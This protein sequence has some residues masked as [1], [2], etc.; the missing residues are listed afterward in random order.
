MTN[1]KSKIK[2]LILRHCVLPSILLLA[3]WLQ[4]SLISGAR[5]HPDE[6][7]YATWARV[8]ATG[9]DVWLAQR[10]VDKPPL[11]IYAI[12]IPFGTV[13]ASEEL[14]RLPNVLA[15]LCA[16]ALLYGIAHSLYREHG[17]AWLAAGVFALSPYTLLFAPTA[18]TDPFMLGWV[19]LAWWL[20][21]K[22]R[23]FYAGIAYGLALA[24][25]QDAILLLPLL[26]IGNWLLAMSYRKFTIKYL[27][28]HSQYLASFLLGWLLPL[29]C[30]MGWS[31]L[32]PQLNYLQAS[33]DHYGGVSFVTFDSYPARLYA[34]V[35][36][37]R[38]LSSEWLL[39]L[40]I[41]AS[42]FLMARQRHHA[43]IGVWLFACYWFVSH[44][45][46]SLQVWDR[47]L[48]PLAPIAA[49]AIARSVTFAWRHRLHRF[50]K[51]GEV[52]FIVS[53]AVTLIL[54][55]RAVLQ[56][57][58]D[59]SGMRGLYDGID[60]VGLFFWRTDT[61]ATILYMRHLSWS[62]DYYT[63]GR[64]LDRR[65]V[66]NPIELAADAGHMAL[67]KKFLVLATWEHW[68]QE[69]TDALASVNL[70]AE[71][72]FITYHQ[73][74]TPSLIVYQLTPKLV[75]ISSSY[76]SLDNRLTE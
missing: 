55:A 46:L 15:S 16:I 24:T 27:R 9:E 38:V 74:G 6:A 60:E 69:L 14:A 30:V 26:V 49:L 20:T 22:R 2:N 36:L 19:L 47:Y 8:V 12:A 11:F 5:F 52:L 32:R 65:W 40:A 51:T 4:F 35:T 53:L 29:S 37:A 39:L 70:K 3:A 62:I 72:V 25:K 1:L 21:L 66:S 17:V 59:V 64:A 34:W 31:L 58:L 43:D 76:S 67:A 75:G 44:L 41:A 57:E 56:R 18:F 68:G 63:F 48:L 23:V 71:P 42:P 45:V 28:A 54:P 33:L 10:V 7:L 13:G 73:D 50:S 61:T